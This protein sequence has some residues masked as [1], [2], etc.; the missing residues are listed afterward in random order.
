[1]KKILTMSVVMLLF[2]LLLTG[3]YSKQT[4][5]VC[6]QE[7]TGPTEELSKTDWREEYA[8]T[9]GTQ[10]YI[11]G[12]P[13]VYLSQIRYAWVNHYRNP[14]TPYAA[15]NHFWH[16]KYFADAAYRDGGSPN[17]DTLYSTAWVDLR[18]GPVILSHPDLGDRFFTFEIA[19]MS[20]DNVVAVGQNTT[21]SDAGHFAIVGHEWKG[22]LPEGVQGLPASTTPFV[23]IFGRTMV[24]GKDDVPA[25]LNFMEQ[26]KLTPLSLWGKENATVPENRDVF[27][28]FDAK[29]DPLADWKTMNQNMTENPPEPRHATLLKQF[30][31]IGIGPDQDVDSL[32][33]PTKRGLARAAIEGRRI[34]TESINNP[35]FKTINGWKYPPPYMGRAGEVD[36]FL[37]RGGKQCMWGIISQDPPEATYLSTA[38]DSEGNKLTGTN[39]YTIH[40]PPG[41][42]PEVKALWSLTLYDNTHN[43]VDNSLDRYALGDRSTQMKKDVDGVTIYIQA[44]SPGIDKESNWLP[45]PKDEP[46]SLTLR[47]YIPGKEIVEQTWAPPQVMRVK[48]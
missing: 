3:C 39:S 44:E 1:M 25:A 35:K 13:W 27:K 23:L 28:P 20:S 48:E 33:E 17:T 41:G 10:A 14:Y 2:G 24:S 46:F 12:Y 11:F 16:L 15:L 26:Y 32:D 6:T 31:D 5:D 4:N 30:A 34:L 9:L 18:E 45:A 47:T 38:V 40:F 22:D 43:F 7:E 42:L 36:D 37:T 29:T 8:Y 21:G 19:A